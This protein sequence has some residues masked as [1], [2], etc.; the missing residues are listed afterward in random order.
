MAILGMDR[1]IVGGIL[2]GTVEDE[3]GLLWKLTAMDW[4]GWGGLVLIWLAAVLTLLTGWD[5][6][7]KAWP[8]LKGA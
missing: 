5:Y 3:V 4:T 7:R 2:D 1:T 6:L 8:Y